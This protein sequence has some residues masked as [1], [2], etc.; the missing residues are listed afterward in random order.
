VSC[1]DL[2]AEQQAVLDQLASQAGLGPVDPDLADVVATLR[3]WGWIFG[4]R[5][6]LTGTG[7]GTPPGTAEPA[8]TTTEPAARSSRPAGNR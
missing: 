3:E 8:S 7:G 4:D 2:T 1:V 6:E 5:P